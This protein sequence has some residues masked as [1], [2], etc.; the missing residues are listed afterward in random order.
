MWYLYD[1]ACFT[2]GVICIVHVCVVIGVLFCLCFCG[3]LVHDTVLWLCYVCMMC[4]YECGL[5][6]LHMCGKNLLFELYMCMC[7]MYA[8]H[9]VWSAWV[10]VCM[11]YKYGWILQHVCCVPVGSICAYCVCCA[12][13]G[14]SLHMWYFTC[15][16]VHVC[17]RI[18]CVL[19]V[20][21]ECVVC[22]L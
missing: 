20:C 13:G 12:C 10:F 7:A 17:T 15:L 3:I 8:I 21:I 16:W 14:V 4:L 2:H 11:W 1:H 22:I 18:W 6:V 5:H 9:A 19:H